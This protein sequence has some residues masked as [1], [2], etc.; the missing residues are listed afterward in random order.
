MCFAFPCIIWYIGGHVNAT[1]DGMTRLLSSIL[2]ASGIVFLTGCLTVAHKDYFIKLKN[3]GGGEATIRFLDIQSEA[4]DTLDVS[5]DDFEQLIDYYLHGSQIEKENPGFSNVTKR[6]YEEDSVLIGEISFTFDSLA[7]VRVFQFDKNSP[8][9]YYV[10]N[11]LS[12]EQL[13]ETNGTAG[14]DWIPLVF[15]PR[16]TREFHI[17]TR[18]VSEGTYR[19]SLIT[20]F[21]EWQ[22]AQKK[23]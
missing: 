18:V 23:Q 17:K 20:H 7:V 10:G 15:W 14:P 13:V 3:G 1:T 8:Y 22:S 12:A 9:M 2:L 11:P 16:E 5:R 21:R 4:D 19:R 6:L